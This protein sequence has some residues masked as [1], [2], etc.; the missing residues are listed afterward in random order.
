MEFR[1]ALSSEMGI[2]T[3]FQ[4]LHLACSSHTPYD[5]GKI[6]SPPIGWQLVLATVWSIP[7]K[8][9]VLSQLAASGTTA[10]DYYKWQKYCEG[11]NISD[12][13][14][15]IAWMSIV[16]IWHWGFINIFLRYRITWG[17]VFEWVMVITYCCKPKHHVA[18]SLTAK[19]WSYPSQKKNYNWMY[20]R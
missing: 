2:T 3:H 8:I 20:W 15:I 1:S 19:F 16:K 4:A 11:E 14:W 13:P 10:R 18:C 12:R 6:T 7:R 9:M 17:L 5:R